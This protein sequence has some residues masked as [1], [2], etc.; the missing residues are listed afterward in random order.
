MGGKLQTSS[1]IIPNVSWKAEQL[2]QAAL[3]VARDKLIVVID[4]DA[5]VLEGMRGL[6]CNWGCRVVTAPTPE[7]ALTEV[8]RIGREARPDL[9]IS[10]YHLADGQ[11]GITATAKLREA[12][13]AVP[14]FVMSGD[15]APERLREAHESG[16]HLLHKPVQPLTLRAMVNRLLKSGYRL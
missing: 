12:Y 9:I 5:L 7:A 6:L 11:S 15:T 1:S 8:K 16:H 10:D 2:Q 4:H 13:G 3:D 14:A